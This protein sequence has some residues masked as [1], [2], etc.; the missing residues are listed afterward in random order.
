MGSE[1][2]KAFLGQMFMRDPEMVLDVEEFCAY[3]SQIDI[4]ASVSIE[5]ESEIIVGDIATV[6]ARI[7]RTN[8]KENEA[9]GPVHAPFYPDNKIEEWWL[10]LVD[11]TTSASSE[12]RIVNFERITDSERSF[13]AELRF[14]VLKEGEN[15]IFLHALNDSYFGVDKKVEIRF[16][17]HSDKVEKRT[18]VVHPE[19]EDL[20]FAPTPYQ[21]FFGGD[22]PGEEE[23]SD[24]EEEEVPQKKSAGA[25]PAAPPAAEGHDSDEF[26]EGSSSDSE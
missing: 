21:Q 20:D 2:R 23:E 10:F 12:P 3:I 6:T 1:L 25:T 22:A 18:Y 19:D 9:A 5:D 17:A 7:L 8:L 14:Q 13:E 15:V 24:E 4:S 11:D 16:F 26:S